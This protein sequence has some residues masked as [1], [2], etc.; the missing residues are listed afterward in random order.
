MQIKHIV[1]CVRKTKHIIPFSQPLAVQ[2]CTNIN[3]GN[4][5]KKMQR[6]AQCSVCESGHYF[7]KKPTD[8]WWLLKDER[9]GV[10]CCSNS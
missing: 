2:I 4:I 6:Q 3:P 5:K 10:V 1:Q 7:L 9:S 8:A